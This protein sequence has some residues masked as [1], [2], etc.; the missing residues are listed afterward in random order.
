MDSLNITAKAIN[1]EIETTCDLL[2]S[3]GRYSLYRGA[4]AYNFQTSLGGFLNLPGI[5]VGEVRP[6]N[7]LQKTQEINVDLVLGGLS[8]IYIFTLLYYAHSGFKKVYRYWKPSREE[9]NI[10]IL[11]DQRIRRRKSKSTR[12]KRKY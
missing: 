12:S 1:N 11:P 8:L 10:E 3:E 4:E 5:K 7:V 2:E 9:N 6:V